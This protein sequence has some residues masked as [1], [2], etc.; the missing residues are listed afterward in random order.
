M[1]TT[2]DVEHLS[3]QIVGIPSKYIQDGVDICAVEDAD[4]SKKRH[5]IYNLDFIEL[6]KQDQETILYHEKGH[7]VAIQDRKS[8][9]YKLYVSDKI[10]Y[11]YAKLYRAAEA[12]ADLYA[13]KHV[14]IDKVMELYCSNRLFTNADRSERRTRI[15]NLRSA[16]AEYTKGHPHANTTRSSRTDR[17]NARASSNLFLR[18]LRILQSTL[19]D[20][21]RPAINTNRC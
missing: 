16:W 6:S 20:M 4:S 17:E 12:E 3:Q 18:A 10:P 19:R 2:Y 1:F 8:A 13:A 7:I 21:V 14:G 15:R 5:I 9:N 11:K